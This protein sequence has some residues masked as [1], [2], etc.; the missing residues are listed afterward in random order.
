RANWGQIEKQSGNCVCEREARFTIKIRRGGETSAVRHRQLVAK[1]HVATNC[2]VDLCVRISEQVQGCDFYQKPKYDKQMHFWYL[3]GNDVSLELPFTL[4]HPK[5][6]PESD[7][8][9]LRF[10]DGEDD[11]SVPAV[12]STG[13]TAAGAG[14]GTVKAAE[15]SSPERA[16]SKQNDLINLGND[17]PTNLPSSDPPTRLSNPVKQSGGGVGQSFDEDDLIF[18][19]FARL[20]LKANESDL[21]G[22]PQEHS[23]PA[24]PDTSD[25]FT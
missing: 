12:V 10:Q 2:L 5:P 7:E 6:I 19:D 24:F 3:G 1:T 9:G 15:F 16:V 18:E 21:T 13:V 23:V 8:V 25:P 4:T 14:T 17:D 20:R 11:A 22:T